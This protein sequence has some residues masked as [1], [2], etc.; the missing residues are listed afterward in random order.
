MD[1]K[2]LLYDGQFKLIDKS[3]ADKIK[4]DEFNAKA[5]KI[6]RKNQSHVKSKGH[7]SWVK[8]RQADENQN[9]MEAESLNYRRR[10]KKYEQQSMI[11]GQVTKKKP[12]YFVEPIEKAQA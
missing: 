7:H 12:K 8:E 6:S 4:S 5:E 9:W 3:Q 2:I 1:D 11:Q 10:S